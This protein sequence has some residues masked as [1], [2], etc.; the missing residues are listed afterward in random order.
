MTTT[1][2]SFTVEVG[3]GTVLFILQIQIPRKVSR[4]ATRRIKR[5]LQDHQRPSDSVVSIFRRSRSFLFFIT[6]GLEGTSVAVYSLFDYSRVGALSVTYTMDGFPLSLSYDTSILAHEQGV[7][8][9]E[10]TLMFSND[11]L[12]SGDHTLVLDVTVC[13]GQTFELDYIL[14]SPSFNT[15]ADK[16][17]YS[18]SS[19]SSTRTLPAPSESGSSQ[20]STG[21]SSHVGAIVG[22]VIGGIAAIL[23][24]FFIILCRK[25]LASRHSSSAAA[26]AITRSCMFFFRLPN[27]CAC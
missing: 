17:N 18:G 22:G 2:I 5:P 7:L 12:A 8:T 21:K 13:N 10:N 25:R 9:V 20:V 19:T 15:L 16:P 3:C 24:A 4:I 26:T 11:S 14:Y 6:P 23:I 27:L 1:R